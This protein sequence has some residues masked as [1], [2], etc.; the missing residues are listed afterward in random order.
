MGMSWRAGLIVW[1]SLL[2]GAAFVL[3]ER[4]EARTRWQCTKGP[5]RAFTTIR[6]MRGTTRFECGGGIPWLGIPGICGDMAHTE[7]E[8]WV[9]IV[10]GLSQS[11][12][13]HSDSFYGPVNGE[14]QGC[15]GGGI[16]ESTGRKQIAGV[17]QYQGF[18]P[19][20]FDYIGFTSLVTNIRSSIESRVDHVSGAWSS[21][22]DLDKC[23]FVKIIGSIYYPTFA[24]WPVLNGGDPDASGPGWATFLIRG[25]TGLSC[26]V[27]QSSC[28]TVVCS[29]LQVEA[30][31]YC[32]YSE[33]ERNELPDRG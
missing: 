2:L 5:W 10:G 6:Q 24:V 23:T 8:S 7:N 30:T 15:F 21:V 17:A 11:C 16:Q 4:A 18:W 13:D 27:K 3:P 26:S 22:Y 12:E 19:T 29:D 14:W 32:E 9:D 28:E 20:S 1:L 31:L 33:R 25:S